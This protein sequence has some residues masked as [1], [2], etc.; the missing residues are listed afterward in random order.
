MLSKI[1][2]WIDY[3]RFIVICP[4]AGILIWVIAFG[5]QAET[6]SPVNPNKTVTAVELETEFVVWQKEQEIVLTRFDA[7]RADIEKQ[8]AAWNEF[9]KI[10]I[11]YLPSFV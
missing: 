8:Q 10:L 4:V 3:N 5:C 1:W 9:E 6:I 2:K 7:A 11:Q